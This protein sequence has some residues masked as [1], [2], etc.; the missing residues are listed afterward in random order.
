[1]W[2]EVKKMGEG[3]KQELIE[4]IKRTKKQS[5]KGMDKHLCDHLLWL[6][7]LHYIQKEEK[8]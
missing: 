5:K 8:D 3:I 4:F 2:I 6:V 7:K 1:M